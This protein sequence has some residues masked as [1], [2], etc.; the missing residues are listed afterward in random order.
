M[1]FSSDQHEDPETSAPASAAPAP[2]PAWAR[3]AV[4]V[5]WEET[6]PLEYHQLL[7][8]VPRPRWWKP[9]VGLLLGV[10]YYLTLSTGF[11][12]VMFSIAAARSKSR[13]SSP[14]P[15]RRLASTVSKP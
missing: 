12:L 8:G 14:Y 10:L 13:S 9:L 4:E 1:T 6:E 11:T 5:Q 15:R 2:Q 3:Q 7:R